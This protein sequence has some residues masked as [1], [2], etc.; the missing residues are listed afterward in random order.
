M[1]YRWCNNCM[2][3]RKIMYSMYINFILNNLCEYNHWIIYL[4]VSFTNRYN[5][6]KH[7]WIKYIICILIAILIVVY[8]LI[9]IDFIYYNLV[10]LSVSSIVEL[11]VVLWTASTA[12]PPP[13]L[14]FA[15]I[16]ESG[17]HHL[18]HTFLF[19]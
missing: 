3:N 5:Q 1:R 17:Y 18:P 13:L 8:A 6:R 12:A 16:L 11:I 7:I 9:T 19:K 4:W 15:S 10:D 14:A 2:S